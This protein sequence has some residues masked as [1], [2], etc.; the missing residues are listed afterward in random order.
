MAT[1]SNAGILPYEFPGDGTRPAVTIEPGDTVDTDWN[2]NQMYFEWVS[3]GP[4][5]GA[6][7]FNPPD[8]PSEPAVQADLAPAAAAAAAD[9]EE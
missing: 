5:E 1:Y 4:P 6:G 8:L 3:G 2:P 7:D 9:T